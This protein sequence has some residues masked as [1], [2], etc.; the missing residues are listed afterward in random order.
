MMSCL[1]VRFW[2]EGALATLGTI[3]SLLTLSW[4]NWI[5]LA[6]GFDPDHGSGVLEW[7]IVVVA[8]IL[9]A[10]CFVLARAEWQRV[11]TAAV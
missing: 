5:E 10:T 4:P 1:R 7:S 9:T 2:V 8:V 3:A 11:R 6:F